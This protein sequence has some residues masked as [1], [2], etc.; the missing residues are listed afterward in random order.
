MVAARLLMIWWERRV[1]AKLAQ[2]DLN[3]WLG[4]G[5]VEDLRFILG[6]LEPGWRWSKVNRKF[7]WTREEAVN[8]YVE[9]NSVEDDIVEK[10]R[11]D[12]QDSC[13]TELLEAMSALR[14]DDMEAQHE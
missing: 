12:G 7:V 11:G 8:D 9:E 13:P 6:L 1:K 3:S 5:Y 2:V 14:I 4:G 10:L